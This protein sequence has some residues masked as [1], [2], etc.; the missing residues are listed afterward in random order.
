MH[1]FKDCKSIEQKKSIKSDIKIPVPNIFNVLKYFKFFFLFLIFCFL[2]CFSVE[3]F[4]LSRVKVLEICYKYITV[5]STLQLMCLPSLFS[6]VF[7][8]HGNEM[9]HMKVFATIQTTWIF[10]EETTETV[11]DWLWKVLTSAT[12]IQGCN[13]SVQA[14]IVATF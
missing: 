9:Q 4:C 7:P 6:T 8:R 11:Y 5:Y 13:N 10:N 12:A 2:F 3:Y 14:G 1:W